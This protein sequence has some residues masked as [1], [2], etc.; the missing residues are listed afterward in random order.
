MSP[1]RKCQGSQCHTSKVFLPR[2][3]GPSLVM[4]KHQMAQWGGGEPTGWAAYSRR[5]YKPREGAGPGRKEGRRTARRWE[6]YVWVG[7]RCHIHTGFSHG[8]VGGRLWWLYKSV[9]AWGHTNTGINS[10]VITT[11]WLPLTRC[12]KSL[13]EI[14]TESRREHMGD[15]VNVGTC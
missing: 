9:L 6:E 4:K 5:H 13:V 8:E 10:G 15:K 7:Q 12:A 2:M 1:G 11:S 14:G 3:C